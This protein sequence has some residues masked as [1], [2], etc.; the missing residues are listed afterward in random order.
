MDKYSAL[1]ASNCD[2]RVYVDKYAKS[3]NQGSGI[4]TEEAMKHIIVNNY[5][6]F[7][8]GKEQTC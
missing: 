1:Y 4:S 8:L 3:Y 7:I 6:E 5:G 2:F